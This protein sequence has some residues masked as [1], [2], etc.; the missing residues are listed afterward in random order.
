MKV[1]S[2][3]PAVP[4]T[5]SMLLTET[6]SAASSTSVS[7]EAVPTISSIAEVRSVPPPRKVTASGPPATPTT[8]STPETTMLSL[9]SSSTVSVP[10]EPS[11]D[12]MADTDRPPAPSIDTIS[13]V[14]VV[15]V[16]VSTRLV[17][18]VP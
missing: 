17:R 2:S 1:T 5:D 9:A 18:S 3:T 15:P 6:F 7:A 14:P 10:V 13:P 12:S 8:V 11:T 4:T 16:T